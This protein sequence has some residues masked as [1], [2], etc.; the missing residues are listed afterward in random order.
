[1]KVYIAGPMTGLPEFNFPLFF[2]AEELLKGHGFEV[3]NPAR[4]D[5]IDTSGMKGDLS[6]VPDFCLRKARSATVMLLLTV[7]TLPCCLIGSEAGALQLSISWLFI[8]DWT[9]S[10]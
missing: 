7:R 9:L 5:G 1:M 8:L 6:E 3:I 4:E 10:I 2:E